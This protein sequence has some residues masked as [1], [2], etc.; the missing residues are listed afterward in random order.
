M[1]RWRGDKGYHVCKEGPAM[2][3][4]VAARSGSNNAWLQR[5]LAGAIVTLAA[6]A[7]APAGETAVLQQGVN[8]YA[9]CADT[10]MYYFGSYPA[11]S[12]MNEGAN[13]YLYI[14]QC[15]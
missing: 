1:G 8:G 3:N 7:S 10:Y 9:G 4:Q 2:R 13:Q 14:R 6:A 12:D 5:I 15:P 11:Y